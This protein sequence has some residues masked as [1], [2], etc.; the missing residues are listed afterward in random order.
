MLPGNSQC[1][2][3]PEDQAHRFYCIIIPSFEKHA[4]C[5]GPQLLLASPLALREGGGAV[6]LHSLLS[7][8][9]SLQVNLFHFLVNFIFHLNFHILREYP[10]CEPIVLVR[11]YLSV[12]DLRLDNDTRKRVN[13]FTPLFINDLFIVAYRNAKNSAKK[14]IGKL[15]C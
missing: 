13:Y 11:N 14:L 7:G 6:Q 4:S 10:V 15:F 8:P 12:I 9:K 3:N 2:T 1:Q 5:A